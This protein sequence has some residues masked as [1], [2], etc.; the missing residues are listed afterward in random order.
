MN[1]NYQL[2]VYGSLRK[3][4]EHPVFK[5]ISDYFNFVSH[6]KVKGL[7]YDF[8]EYPAAVPDNGDHFI[9]GEL[10][11]VK[12]PDEFSYAIGQ[13]DD[14]EG[15]N[16]AEGS[17]LYRREKTTVYTEQG[18]TTGWVYWYNGYINNEPLITSGDVL[19]Y[20][21]EKYEIPLPKGE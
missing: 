11:T 6:G 8:G 2:F 17:S 1:T 3:G 5:Y 15:I 18:T 19:A 7:L 20:A 10:Y 12:E 14:Y 9:I 21:R 4:F 13:L 16:P